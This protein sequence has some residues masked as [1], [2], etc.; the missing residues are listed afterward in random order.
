MPGAAAVHRASLEARHTRAYRCCF[1]QQLMLQS[2]ACVQD[3]QLLPI[4]QL[5]TESEACVPGAAAVYRAGR[6]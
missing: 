5:I 4:E 1:M 6:G 3:A 2:E